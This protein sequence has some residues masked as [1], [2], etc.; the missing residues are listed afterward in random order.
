MR[1]ESRKRFIEAPWSINHEGHEGH[2]ERENLSG[3]VISVNF[4]VH[5]LG[6]VPQSGPA[7]R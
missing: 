4:V 1:N 5:D 6:R 7:L 2:E 3:F